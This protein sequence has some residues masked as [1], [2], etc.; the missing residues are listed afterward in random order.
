MHTQCID[1]LHFELH[2]MISVGEGSGRVNRCTPLSKE[3]IQFP[4]HCEAH[5]RHTFSHDIH[6]RWVLFSPRF[7]EAR[8]D[9]GG[10]PGQGSTANLQQ[11]Q[12]SQQAAQ[13]WKLRS[14]SG[15]TQDVVRGKVKG[16]LSGRISLPPMRLGYIFHQNN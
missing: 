8:T 3:G 13:H 6:T 1:V 15:A 7:T 14:S 10:S 2:I 11:S 5:P 9:L 12:D 16:T 4:R